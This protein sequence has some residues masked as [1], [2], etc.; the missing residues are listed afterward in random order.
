MSTL[1]PALDEWPADGFESVDR[2]PACSSQTRSLMYEGVTDRSYLHAP[3]RWDLHR[4][5]ACSAAYLDPRPNSQTI[6]LAYGNYYESAGAVRP[7]NGAGSYRRMRRTIRNGYLNGRYGYRLRPATRLGSVVVPLLPGL[8]EMA[9]EHVRHLPAMPA[10]GCS[11]SAAARASS[12]PRWRRSGGTRTESIR[13]SMRSPRP[14]RAAF[15]PPSA[16]SPT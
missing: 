12:S 2:C 7:A 11:M 6:H 14:V 16:T 1:A 8:R 9:D 5:D 10:D 13:A 4:C 15:G 3:G